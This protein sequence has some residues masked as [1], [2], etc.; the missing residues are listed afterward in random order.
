MAQY[1]AIIKGSRGE[2]SRL[3]HKANGIRAEVNGWNLGI[4]VYGRFDREKGDLFEV[5]LTGGSKAYH[6]RILVGTFAETERM[7]YNYP[8]ASSHRPSRILTQEQRRDH[9]NRLVGY[10]DASARERVGDLAAFNSNRQHNPATGFDEW[11]P[12]T[13]EWIRDTGTRNGWSH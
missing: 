5:Y 3:G 12:D 6:D 1:R 11:L 4:L 9:V 8:A 2:A 10:P 7:K 13:P